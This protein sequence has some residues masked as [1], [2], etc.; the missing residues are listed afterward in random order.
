MAGFARTARLLRPA[1][2]KRV[3]SQGRKKRSASFTAYEHEGPSELARLGLTVSRKAMPRA[4]D[5]N[6]FKRLARESFRAAG[7]LPARDV[8]IMASP[9]ARKTARG[10]LATELHDYWQRLREQWSGSSLS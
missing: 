7:P 3:M 2:F 1:D 4:V 9:T 8:V 6:R 5:R 10:A